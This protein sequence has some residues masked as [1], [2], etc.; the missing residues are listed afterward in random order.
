MATKAKY[1]NYNI[2]GSKGVFYESEKDLREGFNI[3]FE[4][5]SKEIRYHRESQSLEGVLKKIGIKK[6]QFDKGPVTYL[7]IMFEEISGEL[8]T[9]SIPVF[10]NKGGIDPWIKAFMLYLPVLKKGQEIQIALNRKNRDKNKF[11]YKNVWMHDGDNE[12][13]K[14]AF[15]PKPEA[16]IVPKPVWAKNPVTDEEKW[17]YTPVDKWYY[18]YLMKIVDEWGGNVEEGDESTGLQD[19]ESYVG[20]PE[21]DGEGQDGAA[22]DDLPF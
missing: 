20:G 9:L 19:N 15:D 3:R 17:D 13:I 4:T 8:G 10:T 6:Q 7:R 16:G 11:L 18:D 12:Q 21:P 22:Y 2:K 5:Q 14:W 1:R